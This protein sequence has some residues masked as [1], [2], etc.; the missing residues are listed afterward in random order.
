ML[1]TTGQSRVPRLALVMAAMAALL[2]LGSARPNHAEAQSSSP[3]VDA[4]MR[5]LG[6]HG[7][8]CWTFMREIVAEATGRQVGFDYRQGFVEAGAVEVSAED[9]VAGDIIQIASDANTS[10]WASYSGLHTAIVIENLGGGEFNAIDSNQNWDEMVALRPGYDPYAAA[11][12][13][14]LQVHIY[15][16]PTGSGRAG[17]AIPAASTATDWAAGDTAAV[18]AGGDCLNL[19]D[20]P[21]LGARRIRCIP[22]G[23]S[24]IA[25]GPAVAADG[26]VWLEVDSPQ[27]HG[28]VAAKYLSRTATASPPVSASEPPALAT[29]P[30]AEATAPEPVSAL[31]IGVVDNS[32][33]C[34]RLRDAATVQG[35]IRDCMAAGASL[36]ILSDVVV[37]GDGYN[38]LNVRTPGG[39]D[40]WVASE[41]VIR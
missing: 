26:F 2:L 22:S 18:A 37:A 12:R 30:A 41:F 23:A 32:P 7:G 24:V 21:A 31:A 27:G 5:Q 6:T 19:R 25:A 33:G 1:T 9:A 29:A 4:A 28:W 8:Q 10:P 34:L 15:R 38:W 39:H 11:A 20:A 3:I 40:G 14:G 13:Y 17:D 36:T 16:I 35:V